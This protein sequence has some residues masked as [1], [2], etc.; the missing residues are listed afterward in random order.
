MNLSIADFLPKYPF[1]EDEIY[2]DQNSIPDSDTIRH[3]ITQ[4]IYPENSEF[5]NFDFS[6][7]NYLIPKQKFNQIIFDK[8]EYFEKKLSSNPEPK[9]KKVKN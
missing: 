7:H 3:N 6:Q 2:L 8:E 4:T 9:P 5:E 1:I